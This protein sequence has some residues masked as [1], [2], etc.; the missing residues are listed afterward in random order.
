MEKWIDL[1]D[2][3]EVK[4]TGHYQWLDTGEGWNCWGK[5]KNGIKVP[6]L[7]TWMGDKTIYWDLWGG[8]AFVG[9]KRGS[10][11]S[12]LHF[13]FLW[14]IDTEIKK[15][16]IWVCDSNAQS[17]IMRGQYKQGLLYGHW[18]PII[19][20]WILAPQGTICVTLVKFLNIY[21]LTFSFLI[22]NM[23]ITEVSIL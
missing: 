19:W 3:E 9:R 12:T 10:I 16:D 13:R 21:I 15:L 23:E 11:L 22:S 18:S 7:P 1:K 6:S 5:V 2:T 4:E 14:A 20:A 8:K 17:K